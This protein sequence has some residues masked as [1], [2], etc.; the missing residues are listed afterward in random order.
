MH[1]TFLVS[2]ALIASLSGPA[3]A[4]YRAPA[5]TLIDSSRLG[6]S[7]PPPP[8]YTPPPRPASPPP[9]PHVDLRPLPP[10]PP[11]PAYARPLPPPPPPPAPARVEPTVQLAPPSQVTV[12]A[13]I[14]A[15]DKVTISPSVTG[16]PPLPN[17]TPS[18][19]GGGISVR[20]GPKPSGGLDGT[21]P[22]VTDE[23]H[24]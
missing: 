22:Q 5:G 4:D 16:T 23:N 8:V 14:R 11:P 15:S 10:P 17:G 21:T 12:G 9:A 6:H 2:V 19:D 24:R 7:L 20:V 1:K 13:D 18:L 3:F